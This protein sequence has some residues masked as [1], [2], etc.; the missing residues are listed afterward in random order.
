MKAVFSLLCCILSALALSAAD[1]TASVTPSGAGK[2]E[3]KIKLL[4]SGGFAPY[5]FSWT[6]PAGYSSTL[7]SPEF[8]D[9]GTYCV[10]V[11]D[12]YC[13]TASLCVTVDEKPTAIGELTAVSFSVYPNPFSKRLFISPGNQVNGLVHL[14]LYDYTG[15]LVARLDTEAAGDLTWDLG[16]PLAAGTYILRAVFPDGS[17]GQSR[18]QASGK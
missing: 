4:L 9:P 13:G 2:K 7:M 18:V 14:T 16:A 11:T 6:G 15:R 17:T 1:L 12:Q 5:T 8:L 10:T 3:G